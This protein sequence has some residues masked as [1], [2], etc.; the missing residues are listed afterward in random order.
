M[1]QTSGTRPVN[2]SHKFIYSNDTIL[3]N[4]ESYNM[5]HLSHNFSRV[6]VH[7][8]KD[9]TLS[10]FLLFISIEDQIISI[11]KNVLQKRLK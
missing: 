11:N 9:A 6:S 5:I 7:A 8:L 1:K 2:I 3:P 10:I 4:D